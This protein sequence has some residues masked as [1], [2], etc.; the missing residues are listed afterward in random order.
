MSALT[1]RPQD[2][3]ALVLGAV[4]L[5]TLLGFTRIVRP[6]M[7]SLA[8][9]R[10][11][12]SAQKELLARER[13]LLAAAPKLPQV[14]RNVNQVLAAES[15]RLFAGDSVAASAEL[16]SFVTDVASATGVRV[17]MVEG[18]PPRTTSGVSRLSVDVR[19][20]GTWRQVL[21]FIRSVESSGHLVDASS[22]R[23]ERG[24]RGG[25]LGGSLVSVSATLTGYGRGT[26]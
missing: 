8:Q 18:R 20:E 23:I 14:Q 15:A 1:L 6:A 9:E 3:R 22:V 11:A 19:G 26:P 5:V 21:A 24:M 12:L 10:Q 13:A 16:T 25:P 7:A 2:R 4:V 17:S